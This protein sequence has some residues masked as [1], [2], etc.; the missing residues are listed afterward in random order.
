MRS[1]CSTGQ[2]REQVA[3]LANMNLL[4]VKQFLERVHRD[5]PEIAQ[6][7]SFS[8]S[9]SLRGY[10]LWLE[11]REVENASDPAIRAALKSQSDRFAFCR[12]LEGV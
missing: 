2:G 10:R 6:L 9:A 3:L 11:A 7:Q 5:I 8:W 4:H 12:T 1:S